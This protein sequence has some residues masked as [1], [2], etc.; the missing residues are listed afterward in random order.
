MPKE[1]DGA[2]LQ[3]TIH[4]GEGSVLVTQERHLISLVDEAGTYQAPWVL[5]LNDLDELPEGGPW[6]ENVRDEAKRFRRR[7]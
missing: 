3:L 1:N 2:D 7:R 5:R 6:S 4:V